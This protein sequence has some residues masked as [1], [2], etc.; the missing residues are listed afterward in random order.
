M[1]YVA[2]IPQSDAQFSGFSHSLPRGQASCRLSRAQSNR[3]AISNQMAEQ[4]TQSL[5]MKLVYLE[6]SPG[7][8]AEVHMLWLRVS[9]RV[10]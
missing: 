9:R 4:E 3:G 10:E 2:P 8:F 6:Y 5:A 1:G 7:D